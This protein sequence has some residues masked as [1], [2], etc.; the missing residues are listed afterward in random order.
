M[1]QNQKVSDT[2]YREGAGKKAAIEDLLKHQNE[3]GLK[4]VVV[5][6]EQEEALLKSQTKEDF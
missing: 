4:F 2:V 5:D 6:P 3:E 1:E